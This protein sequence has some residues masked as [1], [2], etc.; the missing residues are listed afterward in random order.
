[1]CFSHC[2]YPKIWEHTVV[3][4]DVFLIN[5]RRVRCLSIHMTMINFLHNFYVMSLLKSTNL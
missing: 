1:M 3:V 4:A 2:L 5:K